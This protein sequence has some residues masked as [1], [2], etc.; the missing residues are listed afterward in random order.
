MKKN[1]T[2][3]WGFFCFF[4]SYLFGSFYYSDS[5]KEEE[6]EE[7]EIEDSENEKQNIKSEDQEVTD[8]MLC[9]VM[10]ISVSAV[11]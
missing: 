6:E 5:S 3:P 10:F 2:I 8:S 1:T 7:V 9:Y 4:L 11:F